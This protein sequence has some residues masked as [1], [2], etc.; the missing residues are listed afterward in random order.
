MSRAPHHTLPPN[1]T[2]FL[3][4]LVPLIH[5]STIQ[6]FAYIRRAAVPC[7][8]GPDTPPSLT[9]PFGPT[10]CRDTICSFRFSSFRFVRHDAGQSPGTGPDWSVRV[11]LH[12]TLGGRRNGMVGIW[13]GRG[14]ASG[15]LVARGGG[16]RV[17]GEGRGSEMMPSG[18]SVC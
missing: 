8:D 10:A 2:T 12:V 9:E 18:D 7:P 14:G 11:T 13:T 5:R 17:R 1:A 4:S 16:R 6:T 3:R 15:E